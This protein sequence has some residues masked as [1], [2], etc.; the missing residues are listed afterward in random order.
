MGE[1]VNVV[2]RVDVLTLG[3]LRSRK[4]KLAATSGEA[5]GKVKNRYLCL[6]RSRPPIQTRSASGMTT[7]PSAC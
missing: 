4:L 7:L 5:Y 2:F 6:I 1:H 3:L